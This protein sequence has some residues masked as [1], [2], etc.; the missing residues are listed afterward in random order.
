VPNGAPVSSG[1]AAA[2][3]LAAAGHFAYTTNAASGSIGAFAVARDGSLSLIG[4]TPVGTG[5]HP[6]DEA[7]S[8][9]E[10]FL[11]VL[12]D[13]FHQIDGY[14]VGADGSL[15]QVTSVAVP[16]GAIGAAAR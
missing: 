11:Y 10:H 4:T 8:R 12:V 5:S 6:L 15:T 3:W 2:C 16:A 9:D 13:G 7:V 1:Q 14:R